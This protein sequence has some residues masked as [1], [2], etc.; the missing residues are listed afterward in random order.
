[1]V[2]DWKVNGQWIQLNSG[3]ISHI[4]KDI[5]TFVQACFSKEKAISAIINNFTEEQFTDLVNFSI[6]AAWESN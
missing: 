5:G 3:N 6:S 2:I 1:M 4:Y